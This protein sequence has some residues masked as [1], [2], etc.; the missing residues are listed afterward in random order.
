MRYNL[1][2][3]TLYIVATPIGNLED[4]SL[5]ALRVLL[6]A[7]TVACEDTRQTSR[8]LSLLTER[9]APVISAS[10]IAVD[11]PRLIRYDNDT[12]YREAPGLIALLEGGGD[13]VLVSDAG[14]PLISDPGYFIVSE[15]RKRDIPVTAVPGASAAVTALSIS[16]LPTDRFTFLGY[17]PEKASHRAALFTG[18]RE[19]AERLP[20]TYLLYVAPH[21]L[22]RTLE[23]LRA[24]CG[25]RPI[26]LIRELT[27]V[28]ETYWRGSVTQALDQNRTPK[29]EYVLLFRLP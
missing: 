25:D 24:A 5:R 22:L 15:A 4:I 2:M 16:G 18:I 21:K 8:L 27:K 9:F 13:V 11:T 17:P 14:T 23:D 28:H 3:G 19:S 7:D 6:T 29:G 26:V 10:G 20:A 1:R 12:E